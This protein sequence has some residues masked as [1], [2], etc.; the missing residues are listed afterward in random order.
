MLL[1]LLIQLTEATLTVLDG[2]P[3]VVVLIGAPGGGEPVLQEEL[4]DVAELGV[5]GAVEGE[6]DDLLDVKGKLGGALVPAG[7]ELDYDVGRDLHG[8]GLGGEA[9]VEGATHGEDEWPA[10][11]EVWVLCIYVMS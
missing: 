8:G 11:G 2:Q 9:R 5:E 7:N 4:D 6:L 3:E 1:R 10:L